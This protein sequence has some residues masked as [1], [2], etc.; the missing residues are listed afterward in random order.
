MIDRYTRPEMGAVWTE[1]NKYRQWLAV[2]LAAS[3]ALSEL[4]E[5]PAKPLLH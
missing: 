2:E 4:G 1:E 5:V 3:Q